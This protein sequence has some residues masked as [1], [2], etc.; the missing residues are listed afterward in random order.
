MTDLVAVNVLLEPDERTL[1]RARALN[2]TLRGSFPAGFAFDD[3]HQAHVTV[4]QR[5][6]RTGSL[7]SLFEAVG[8][9][10]AQGGLSGL[11]LRALGLVSAE[12]GTPPG[13]VLASVRLESA[14]A[15]AALQEALVEAV[16]AFT[17]HGGSPA[18]FFVSEGEP[19]VNAA[20]VAYVE[21]FV[22]AG[23]AER[24]GPHISVGVGAKERVAELQARPFEAFE[25]APVAAAVFQLGD[26]GTARRRLRSWPL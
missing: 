17:G 7:G 5:Y 25:V 9:V 15:L 8:D 14:P 10:I 26:L 1:E 24:Y 4:L 22:P 20:T 19:G 6:V 3:S 13:T 2:S 16:A 11:R 23:V 21:E 12:L 18:A